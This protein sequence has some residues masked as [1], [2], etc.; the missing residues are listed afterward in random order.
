MEPLYHLGFDD[1]IKAKY[2]ILPG[3]PGRVEQI[4]NMLDNPRFVHQNR[5]YLTWLGE[6]EGESVL[7]MSTGMGGPSAAI[8]IEEL[9]QCGLKRFIRVG[10]C[11]GMAENIMSGDLVI[12]KGAIRQDGTS[13]EYVPIEFPAIADMSV[14]HALIQEAKRITEKVNDARSEAMQAQ[15]DTP[16]DLS[17]KRNRTAARYHIGI[18][19]SK[20]SFYGQ[21]APDRMP[22]GY[23]LKEKWQAWIK[24]GCLASEMECA[25]MYIVAQVLGIKGGSVLSVVWNQERIASKL[26]S[27]ENHDTTLATEVAVAAMRNLIIEDKAEK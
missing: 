18:V 3:D 9:A 17:I 25:T 15:K 4:A 7:V 1:E 13:K 8:A 23:E 10:T 6:L 16:P 24:A 26:Y 12:A 14:T 5:G 27:V 20:D 19:Q 22:V 21:H 11:G 2:A